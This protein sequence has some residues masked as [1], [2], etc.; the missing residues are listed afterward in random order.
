MNIQGW[1]PLGLTGLTQSHRPFGEKKSHIER[2]MVQV[3]CLQNHQAKD[4]CSSV[5]G[6]EWTSFAD[7]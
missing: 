4:I 3:K 1:F 5:L 7:H 6:K 2:H